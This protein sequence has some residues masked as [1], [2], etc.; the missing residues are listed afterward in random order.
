MQPID[1]NTLIPLLLS[2]GGLCGL[3]IALT[4]K[5]I[6]AKDETIKRLDREISF[7]R[8]EHSRE[9]NRLEREIENKDRKI[10]EIMSS[11]RKLMSEMAEDYERR[12]LSSSYLRELSRI[13]DDS[14]GET[15]NNAKTAA[16]LVMEKRDRWL[17]GAVQYARQEC[18]DYLPEDQVNEFTKDI[19]KYLDWLYESLNS[20]FYRPRKDYIKSHSV[21]SIFPYRASLK[22]LS[23]ISDFGYLTAKE[24]EFIK[25]YIHQ[26]SIKVSG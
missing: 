2:G 26:L 25:N 11:L 17:A 13:Y 3:I 15:R 14:I 8:E 20:G 7:N 16:K 21:E 24:S 19:D 9:K 6:D 23:Q 4:K 1:L 10:D 22:Y 5:E 12:G 18:F